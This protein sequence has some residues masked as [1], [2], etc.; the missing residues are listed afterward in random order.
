VSLVRFSK[1]HP[2]EIQQISADS[3]IQWISKQGCSKLV[4]GLPQARILYADAE[5]RVNCRSF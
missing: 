3:A 2:V 4:V 5:G 1:Y